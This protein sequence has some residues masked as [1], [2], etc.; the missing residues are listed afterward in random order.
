M[1]VLLAKNINFQL[2]LLAEVDTFNKNF[3]KHIRKCL[4]LHINRSN[5]E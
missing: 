4:I 3:N 5:D 1:F 2:F